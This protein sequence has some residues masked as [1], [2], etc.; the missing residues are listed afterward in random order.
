MTIK[1]TPR[2]VS[3]STASLASGTLGFAYSAP[4]AAAGGAPQYSWV[5]S[6][7]SLPLGLSIDSAAGTIGGTPLVAGNFNVTVM[8]TDSGQET[9]SK[10]FS[11]AVAA[12][13]Q[14]MPATPPDGAIGNN[15][16]LQFS[17]TGGT[18]PYAWSLRSGTAPGGLTLDPASGLLGGTPTAAGSFTFAVQARDAMGATA[19]RPFTIAVNASGIMFL[20]TSL[21]RGVAGQDY[22][23]LV[24][25]SG[26]KPPYL[27][28][29]P[30]GSLPNGLLFDATTGTVS[31]RT[32]NSTVTTLTLRAEDSVQASA[33]RDFDLTIDPANGTAGQPYSW[34]FTGSP[35]NLVSGALPDGFALGRGGC[36]VSGTPTTPGVYS[37]TLQPVDGSTRLAH[38]LTITPRLVITT[39]TLADAR[40]G[41]TYSASFAATGGTPPYRWR[42]TAGALPAGLSFDAS[43]VTISGSPTAPGAATF[44]LEVADSNGVLNIA[45]QQDFTLNVRVP[46]ISTPTLSGPPATVTPT[47]QP[48]VSLALGAAY[49]IAITGRLTLSFAPDA[50]NPANDAGIQF[51]TGGNAVDFTIPANTTQAVFPVA[52]LAMQVGTVAGVINFVVSMQAGGQDVTPVNSTLLSTRI[53]RQAPVISSVTASRT[54]SGFDV[55]VIGYATPREVT[56]A[57][58]NFSQGASG[59]LQ[60]TSL[61]VDGTQAFT[62]WYQDMAS[63][64]YGSQFTLVQSFSIQQGD[65]NAVRSVQVTLTNTQGDS[66]P[67]SVSF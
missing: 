56:R 15:Y 29:I 47:Q 37:F 2:P 66:Q 46:P 40:L 39:S 19:S 25:A 32:S 27:Y 64:A 17:A 23:S 22:Q 36:S 48:R 52:S 44:T 62:R 18:R 55:T 65:P 11:L 58:F 8:V 14:I 31:G 42:L 9:A 63:A 60:T 51:S 67:A 20:T 7:G 45:T 49:P 5:I 24:S 59:T 21:N 10:Q 26:G 16:S 3:I 35:C 41:E 54:S 13:P 43:S 33:S 50:V 57:G 61:T 30:A 34:T 38:N 53:E 28:S 4:V 6:P 1:I 12:P